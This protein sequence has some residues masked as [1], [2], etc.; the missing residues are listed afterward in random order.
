MRQ[1]AVRGV[2]ERRVGGVGRGHAYLVHVGGVVRRR[3]EW[4]GGVGAR[5]FGTA[6]VEMQVGE[7]ESVSYVAASQTR[8]DAP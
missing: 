6:R 2:D 5:A 4:D 8:L 1:Q 7:V 3:V